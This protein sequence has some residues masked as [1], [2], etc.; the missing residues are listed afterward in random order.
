VGVGGCKWTHMNKVHIHVLSRSPLRRKR[1][2]QE[3]GRVETQT[4]TKDSPLG[5]DVQP[6]QSFSVEPVTP[7]SRVS[8]P[9]AG[10][11]LRHRCRVDLFHV[12][13]HVGSFTLTHDKA[14][15]ELLCKDCFLAAE[16]FLSIPLSCRPQHALTV[17]SCLQYKLDLAKN[18]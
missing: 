16:T 17:L 1:S 5:L 13:H 10:T 3:T 8:A 15:R 11:P 4:R 7:P 18:N 6:Q 2:T 14:T 12:T 9:A